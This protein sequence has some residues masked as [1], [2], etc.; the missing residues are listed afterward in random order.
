MVQ[1]INY[2]LQGRDP[3]EALF[4]GV[5]QGIG[6]RQAEQGMDLAAAQN[7]RAEAQEAREAEMQP[8]RLRQ[9]EQGLAAGELSME[10]QRQNMAAAEEK[11]QR[12][13]AFRDAM[14]GLSEMGNEATFE[15]YQRVTMQFPEF[16]Q[17]LGETW[18]R[19][20]DNRKRG[21]STRLGQI[22]A[23]I[24]SGN[25]ELAKKLTD[26]YSEAATNSGDAASAAT[27]ES[28]SKLLDVDPKAAY[29]TLGMTAAALGLDWAKDLFGSAKVGA[30]EILADGTI[31]Q[32]TDKGPRVFSA[33]GRVLTG[34][35]ATDAIR[36]GREFGVDVE[37]RK[38]ASRE[39]GKLQTQAE[40]GA[41]ASQ[42][43]KLGELTIEEGGKAY[44]A[45]GKVNANIGT[46]QTAI[47]AI[48]NG[49]KT[50]AVQRYFP[51]ISQSSA[52]LQ[53]AMDRLGLDVI[54]SVTFG[55]LSEGEMRLA[56]ETAVPR[57]LDEVALRDWLAR[58]KEAQEKAADALYNA[59]RYLTTPGNTLNSWLEEQQAAPQQPAAPAQAEV[60]APVDEDRAFIMEMMQL[61]NS[62]QSMSPE[63]RARLKEI[64]ARRG[65]N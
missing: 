22:G 11:R 16:G 20:D 23:A 17:A 49:A 27:A 21:V 12:Q 58:K 4:Q 5:N 3:V 26:E 2:I 6:M 29:S 55:A 57:N 28:I 40:L 59:A 33:D 52:E 56:M 34:Q 39:T 31:I 60:P 63:Q 64:Q 47:D 41:A 7:A 35:D 13:A 14:T 62:G 32:S 15:D 42:A 25:I 8:Y 18:D 53:N 10:A 19:L 9:A 44:E 61:R 46:L 37:G 54:G 24:K 30:Q 43:K 50:G 51:N 65:G 36:A 45:L 1:P 48:D 38:T